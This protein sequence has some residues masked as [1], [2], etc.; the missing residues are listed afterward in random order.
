MQHA[1]MSYREHLLQH[2]IGYDNPAGLLHS[3]AEGVTCIKVKSIHVQLLQT[4][5]CDMAL[6]VPGKKYQGAAVI[7]TVPLGCLKTGDIAFKP[8]LPAWKQEAIE[9]LGFGNLNKVQHAW[10]FVRTF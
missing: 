1:V 7:V 3:M 2:G 5:A 4:H 10:A 9:K 8:S 6:Y